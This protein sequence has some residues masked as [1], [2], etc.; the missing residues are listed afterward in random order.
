[1]YNGA[2][3]VLPRPKTWDQAVEICAAQTAVACDPYSWPNL[4]MPVCGACKALVNWNTYGRTCGGYCSGIGLTCVDGW[5]ESQENCLEVEHLGCDRSYGGTSDAICECYGGSI[6]GKDLC[7]APLSNGICSG[8]GC[9]Y[10]QLYQ[11]STTECEPGDANYP[12]A[13]E[14]TQQPTPAPSLLPTPQPTSTPTGAPVV[15][16]TLT[17]S[18]ISAVEVT[19]EAKTV[20]QNAI[21]D[22]ARVRR[23]DVTIIGVAAARRRR[24]QA[25]GVA[26]DYKI[27]LADFAAAED[28]ANEL[29]NAG[30]DPSVLDAAI[31]GAA[32]DGNV[33][34]VFA[35]VT[36][37][38]LTCDVVAATDA[39]TAAPTTWWA[40][41]KK[42]KEDASLLIIIVVC[43]VAG[44]C[45][46]LAISTATANGAFG[47]CLCF[48]K[49]KK[50]RVA[51]PLAALAPPMAHATKELFPAEEAVVVSVPTEA[52][53]PLPPPKKGWFFRAEPEIEPEA[54]EPPPPPAKSWWFGRAEPEPEEA[55][56]PPPLS[57]FSTLRA[58][59]EQE[60][61]FEP[62]A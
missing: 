62:E 25:G 3:N 26:V 14:P 52:E 20:L 39:P 12:E 2:N 11:W 21:A 28:T 42:R 55:E 29:E 45:C 24:L 4:D 33:E 23:D 15:A 59:R 60:L 49:P 5:E 47:S 13:C 61:A 48:A 44:C 10:N 8:V 53:E 34:A 54:E 36:T 37:D 35:G 50:T 7:A 18:G 9:A 27:E 46:L 40:H 31:E 51:E 43:S 16:G 41:K 19:E 30:D 6:Q 58:Q 38:S 32:K 22:V 17:L 56:R 57:P 1:M